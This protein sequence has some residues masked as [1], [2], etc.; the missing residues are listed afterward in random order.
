MQA[1]PGVSTATDTPTTPAPSDAAITNSP[2]PSATSM[3]VTDVGNTTAVANES[4]T[5]NKTKVVLGVGER[6]RVKAINT[7]ALATYTSED[8][9]IALVNSSG[10]I[11]A[12]KPGSVVIHVTI[13]GVTA[14]ITVQVKKAP[15]KITLKKKSVVLKCGKS[16]AIKYT[17]NKGAAGTVKFSSSN[18]KIAEISKNGIIKAKKAG[19]VKIKCKT[20]NG[21]T[22]VLKVKVKK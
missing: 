19:T 14:D 22:A 18:K 12:M 8:S 9:N 10:K 4:I 20:Y 7:S 2:T 13:N 15:K 6:F 21:K 11:V 16:Y 5:L 3:P 1:T 17:L